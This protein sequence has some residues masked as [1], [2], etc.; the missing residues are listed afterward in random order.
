MKMEPS[1]NISKSI[2]QEVE[3]SGLYGTYNC[4]KEDRSADYYSQD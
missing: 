1:W 3:R 2:P 4:K